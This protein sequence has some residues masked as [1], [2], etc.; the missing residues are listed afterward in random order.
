MAPASRRG[1]LRGLAALP[2]IGGS[3]EL[4]GT[5][6][7][8]AMPVSNDLLSA[9]D[10]WLFYE[11][12]LLL[13]EQ[14]GHLGTDMVRAAERGVP[15]GTLSQSFH[16]PLHGSWTDLPGPSTRVAIILSAA[17]VPLT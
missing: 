15:S 3:V 12:R 6:T 16:F 11:R 2:L 10:Q 14:Y 4:V 1:F 7:A 9:Y 5:P 13:R 17:G 8:S